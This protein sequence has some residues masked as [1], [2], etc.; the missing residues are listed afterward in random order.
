MPRTP[1]NTGSMARADKLQAT[2]H[3]HTPQ[4]SAGMQQINLR[5][6]SVVSDTGLTNQEPA[7]LVGPPQQ[8]IAQHPC[9][10]FPLLLYVLDLQINARSNHRLQ[11]LAQV[12]QR[13]S[14]TV[15]SR[16]ASALDWSSCM[17]LSAHTRLKA[18]MLL[19]SLSGYTSLLEK[20]QS[21]PRRKGRHTQT[22]CRRWWR[23]PA[24]CA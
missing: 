23:G 22:R 21:S 16:G 10:L 20:Q 3:G 5:C 1:A 17:R 9:V 18:P 8:L 12:Q 15:C 14:G 11:K 13:V 2:A 19:D 6:S 7:H 24:A 4:Q